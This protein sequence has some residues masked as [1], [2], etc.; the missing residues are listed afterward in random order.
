M[1]TLTELIREETPHRTVFFKGGIGC[2]F[3]WYSEG[4]VLTLVENLLPFQLSFFPLIGV[5]EI[6]SQMS[7]H[8]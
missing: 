1:P 7:V 6:L 5:E 3:R 8:F 4:Q 2:A